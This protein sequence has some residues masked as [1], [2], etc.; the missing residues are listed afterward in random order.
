M[1]L[2]VVDWQQSSSVVWTK[3]LVGGE[4]VPKLRNVYLKKPEVSNSGF[5]IMNPHNFSRRSSAV[6]SPLTW[7]NSEML[8]EYHRHNSDLSGLLYCSLHD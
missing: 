6:V 8:A 4:T 2:G 7:C 3:H 1:G 5:L